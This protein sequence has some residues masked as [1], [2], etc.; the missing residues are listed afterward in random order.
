VSTRKV[1]D[2]VKAPGSDTGILKPEESRIWSDLDE[3][4][5][6]FWHRGLAESSVPFVFLNLG[7][8]LRLMTAV[9]M[10][11]HDEWAA[12]N[13]RYLAEGSLRVLTQPEN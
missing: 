5:E 9:L 2:L 7:A 1:D 8:L 11:E 6:A 10:E 12:T 4:A 3:D 13:R